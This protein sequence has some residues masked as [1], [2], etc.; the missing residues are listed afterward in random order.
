MSMRKGWEEERVDPDPPFVAENSK[1][2]TH[3]IMHS[4]KRRSP[5]F[6]L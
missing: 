1:N 5:T 4:Q 6:F 3:H 2:G